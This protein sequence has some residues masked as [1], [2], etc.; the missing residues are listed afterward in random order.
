MNFIKTF[1]QISKRDVK[2]VGGKGSSLGELI[3]AGL[4]VPNGFVITT[5]VYKKFS[6]QELSSDV[7][8]DIINAFEKL[9][10]DRVAVRSSA[11]SEDSLSSS[12]AGQLESYL[13]VKK[14]DLISRIRDCWNSMR[15]ER[16][17]S[18]IA[19]RGLEGDN[20]LISVVVQKMIESEVSGVMFSV[21]P[22]TQNNREIMIEAGYGLGEMLV[23]GLITPDNFLVDKNS[24]EIKEKN[25]NAQETMLIYQDGENKEV[26][27]TIG[28]KNE[29]ALNDVQ[30]KELAKLAVLV[31]KHYNYPQDIE[32][33]L[34][35]GKFYLLQSRP[36]TTLSN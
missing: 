16:V 32:W 8:R 5:Q 36:I 14:E 2:E 13:N 30:I 35:K 21:N 17:L 7:I 11:V 9:E 22:I 15:S 6:N 20:L 10:T 31:E 27:I 33:A 4:S 24:L 25:I 29:P 23:Q 26:P 3:R 18:Y 1:D 34:E 28:K 19:E 12:W